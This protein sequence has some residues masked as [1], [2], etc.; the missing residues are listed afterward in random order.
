MDTNKTRA[1]MKGVNSIE[2][3]KK[4]AKPIPRPLPSHPTSAQSVTSSNIRNGIASGLCRG[5]CKLCLKVFGDRVSTEIGQRATLFEVTDENFANGI[6]CS[7]AEP[8]H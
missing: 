3:T 8:G 7:A 6:C 1:I 5:L 2:N 4:P